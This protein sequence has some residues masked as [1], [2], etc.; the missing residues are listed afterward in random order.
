MICRRLGATNPDGDREQRGDD[1]I[2]KRM[3]AVA[4]AVALGGAMTFAGFVAP[5]SAYNYPYYY[6]SWSTQQLCQIDQSQL[7]HQGWTII[8]GCRYGLANR[9]E[10]G[11]EYAR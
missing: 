11:V 6:D 8:V 1:M 3:K 4:A 5:A 9:Y 7:K 10:W 2:S